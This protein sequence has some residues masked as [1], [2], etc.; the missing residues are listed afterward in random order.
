MLF[1]AQKKS[2]ENPSTS[3]TI[4][5]QINFSSKHSS[6]KT[7]IGD[8]KEIDEILQEDSFED[9]TEPLFDIEKFAKSTVLKFALA[10]HAKPNLTRSDVFFIQS[11]VIELLF[12]GILNS[13]EQVFN[14]IES[15]SKADIVKVLKIF[16]KCLEGI[17][18]EHLLTKELESQ[19]LYKNLDSKENEFVINNEVGV[20]FKKGISSFGNLT[21]TGMLLP[22]F[23][24]IKQFL[25]KNNRLNEIFSNLKKYSTPSQIIS[26]IFQGTTWKQIRS[27]FPDDAVVIPIGLYTDG[28]QYNNQTGPHQSSSDMLYYFYPG[29]DDPL[30]KFNIHVASIINSKNIKEYGNGR[31]LAPLVRELF[32]LCLDGV[33][34]MFNGKII[35]AKTVVC[36]IIGDN[37]ALNAILEYI[38]GFSKGKFYCR[39]CR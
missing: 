34:L 8:E 32:R 12:T 38:L 19:E 16:T 17:G 18:T 33:D 31:C 6:D 39:I 37:L 26:H 22:I 25:S 28:V 24:Q 35:N 23:F 14:K 2:N 9:E 29:L 36:Q 7:P 11:L 27:Y 20:I 10:L 15:T 21:T 3:K 4:P 5:L 30:H 13:L 1:N